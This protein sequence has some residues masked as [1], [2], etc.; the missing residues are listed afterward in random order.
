[1]LADIRTDIFRPRTLS[2]LFIIIFTAYYYIKYH[3]IS[4]AKLSLQSRLH[5]T[6]PEA[7]DEGIQ[8]GDHHHVEHRHHHL[9]LV[10]R[11]AGLG[12]HINERVHPIAQSDR[13]EVGCTSGKGL[14]ASLGGAHLQDG[15][16]D[17]DVGGSS[18]TP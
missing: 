14:V 10:R 4:F 18:D 13:C 17:T 9:V 3:K 15:D 8:Y 16:E 5:L 11:V 2:I 12:H 6:L 1:M 7:V